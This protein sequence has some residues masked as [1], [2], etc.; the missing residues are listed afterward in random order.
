MKQFYNRAFLLS[1]A[2]GL[3]TACGIVTP[4]KAQTPQTKE[5]KTII[6]SSPDQGKQEKK[7]TVISSPSAGKKECKMT[8]IATSDSTGSEPQEFDHE[9]F[10]ECMPGHQV[11]AMP[12]RGESLNDVLGDIPMS[13]VKSYKVIDKK[14]GKRIIIDIQDAPLGGDHSNVIYMGIPHPGR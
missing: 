3:I 9:I 5:V 2:A 12:N 7:I 10:N 6:V 4:A 1:F 11:L 14:G 8:V 13:R